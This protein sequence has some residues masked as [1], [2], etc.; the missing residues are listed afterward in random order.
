MY[1]YGVQQCI[2]IIRVITSYTYIYNIYD[3]G[4]RSLN[5]FHCLYSIYFIV[6]ISQLDVCV[7]LGFKLSAA[8]WA[9]SWIRASW[10]T[11]RYTTSV[12]LSRKANAVREAPARRQPY[13]AFRRRDDKRVFYRASY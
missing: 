4:R 3:A 13:R 2:Q 7:L 10:L 6:H 11:A 5:W 9:T 12:S 1:T 8:L